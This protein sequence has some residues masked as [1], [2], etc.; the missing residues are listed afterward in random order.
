MRTE[1]NTLPVPTE[2]QEGRTLVA[3][4]RVKGYRFT[5]IANETGSGRG[6]RFQGIRNKQQGT[7]KGFPDYLVIVN[8][9]LVAIE[10]KRT[11]GSVTSQE[12]KEWI[13]ALNKAGI[14][15]KICKG[16]KEAIDF[17]KTIDK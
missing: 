11:K 12:Q 3:Y 4:L 8:N 2:A 7:S 5:H 13:E 16:A 14:P 15:A 1:R 6:A 9:Q 10:L 17:I